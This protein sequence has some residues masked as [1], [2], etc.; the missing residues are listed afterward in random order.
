MSGNLNFFFHETEAITSVGRKDGCLEITLKM[1][2]MTSVCSLRTCLE[3][4]CS[5]IIYLWE[6]NLYSGSE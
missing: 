6:L 5:I 1:I 3:E 2:T 4:L